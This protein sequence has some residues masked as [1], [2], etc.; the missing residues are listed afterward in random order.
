MKTNHTSRL[1]LNTFV[2]SG[3]GLATDARR[4]ELRQLERL[5]ETTFVSGSLN[6]LSRKPIWLD[7]DSAIYRNGLAIFWNA[8]LNGLPVVIGRWLSGCPAHVFEVFAPL[9]LRDAL[10]L[11]DGDRVILEISKS[12]VST[13]QST[14]WAKFVWAL[15][16]KFRERQV[17]RDGRYLR[18]VSSHRIA[19]YSWKG[20]QR[21]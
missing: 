18:L 13:A 2:T 4:D 19:G 3:R 20:M 11:R 10:A 8:S 5:W 17:Y 15:F 16:W 14:L 7:P 21:R 9:R 12:I 1:R 6:L